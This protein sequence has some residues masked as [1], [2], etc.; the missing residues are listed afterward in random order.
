MNI[1]E[2]PPLLHLLQ[3]LQR[4]RFPVGQARLG[5]DGDEV[6]LTEAV[7]GGSVPAASPLR[8]GPVIGHA[9]TALGRSADTHP[10]TA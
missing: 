2:P 4:L 7:P 5:R 1:I 3:R 9:A 10:L 6:T 8:G